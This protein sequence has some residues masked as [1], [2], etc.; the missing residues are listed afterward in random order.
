MSRSRNVH[1]PLGLRTRGFNVT[2]TRYLGQ[3]STA[4]TLA[5]H[6]V[7]A[8]LLDEGRIHPRSLKLTQ[9]RS[10]FES[11]RKVT[12]SDCGRSISVL[13]DHM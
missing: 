6:F 12:I 2:T 7:A 10:K 13:G 5:L 11:Y 8:S 1:T 9:L 4:E 3:R